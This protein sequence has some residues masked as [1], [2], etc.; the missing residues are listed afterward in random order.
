MKY[1]PCLIIIPISQ[2]ILY[3]Y[4]MIPRYNRPKIEAIW[5][6]ENKYKIWTEIECLIA[7]QLSN[8]KII[9][10]DAAVEIRNKAKFNVDEIKDI[11]KETRHDVVAYINNVSSYIGDQA[12]YFH[13][14]V[15]SSDIIDTSFS[16]QLKQSS[17]IIL[18]Q[19]K[20]LINE[21][22]IKSEEHKNTI[23]IGRSHGIHAEPITFGLKMRS[24]YFEFKRNLERFNYAKEDISIC[25]I[26]GP[27]GTYNTIDPSVEEF[28]AKKLKLNIENISTQVIPRDRHAFFFATLGIIASSIE[29]LSVEIRNLQRTE[30][31]E[32]EEFFNLGQKGSSAMPHKRNPI[33][34]ENL[35]GIAR[36]IR[37]GVIPSMENVALWHERDISHSS[38]E[39]IIAPDITIATDFA[40]SR[41]TDVIKNLIVYPENMKKNLDQLGGLHKSQNILL[42]L[43]HKGLS[44]QEAYKIVQ[45]AAMKS[46]NSNERFEDI[47]MNDKSIK[48]TLTQEEIKKI[49][50]S[51]DKVDKIDWIFNNK[52]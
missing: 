5:L 26:S 39:R 30:L 33:L 20:K 6:D 38:V 25:A 7:E 17:E 3:K 34:S 21:L 31:L 28:V 50:F 16:I 43:T 22:K 14:G 32:V 2:L 52:I 11:E 27:V 35:T 13:H 51:E 49:L 1:L 8:L 29:R 45:S 47:L 12:K 36:Y 15:T 40:L 9:P 23:M 48:K 44:R 4:I 18:E 37:S 41:L 19:L 42:L 24:F 46:W 10:R